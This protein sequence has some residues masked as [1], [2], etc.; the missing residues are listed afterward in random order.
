[1]SQKLSFALCAVAAAL[2]SAPAHA[3]DIVYA[4][5]GTLAQI[6]DGGGTRTII[7]LVNMDSVLAPYQLSFYDDNGNPLT[8]ATTA[9][10]SSTLS[11]AL[12]PLGSIIIQTNG[13]GNL[14]QG[15]AVLISGPTNTIAG[16]AVFGLTLAN[17]LFV[18]ASC[19]LD[20]GLDYI[21][22][23][24]F[25]NTTSVTGVALANSVG[26]GQYQTANTAKVG[27]TVYDQNGNQ[28]LTDTITLAF[29][30]HTAVLLNQQY[31]QTATMKGMVT[32]T[33]LDPMGNSYAIK[34]L[35]VRATDTTYTSVIP[36]I[37]CLSNGTNCTN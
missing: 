16:S 1:M 17:G 36:I 11:G 18:E 25:D 10:T 30:Q 4:G 21:F 37:P 24:P 27:V 14:V 34:T 33:S 7:N 6:M 9:G 20:T 35:G 26:D 32:F 12:S 31:P 22:A 28:V 15:Y 19:P 3:S 23:L 29:G 13:T 2:I 8:L 5:G